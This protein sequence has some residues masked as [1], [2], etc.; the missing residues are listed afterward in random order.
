MI[1]SP[2]TGREGWERLALQ[3]ADESPVTLIGGGSVLSAA[4]RERGIDGRIHSA[5][6]APCWPDRRLRCARSHFRPPS[7]GTRREC[8]AT[9]TGDRSGNLAHRRQQYDQDRRDDEDRQRVTDE[10][11]AGISRAVREGK[12]ERN[13]VIA[14]E[15]ESR[16]AKRVREF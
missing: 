15:R 16:A 5:R 3:A 10:R 1:A 6:F 12:P 13:R 7:G 4:R 8:R 2:V 11:G 14:S 9:G